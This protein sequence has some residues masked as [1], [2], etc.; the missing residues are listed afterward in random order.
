MYR[1]QDASKGFTANIMNAQSAVTVLNYRSAASSFNTMHS[2]Q[3]EEIQV[4]ASDQGFTGASGDGRIPAIGSLQYGRSLSETVKISINVVAMNTAPSILFDIPGASEGAVLR[5]GVE[6]DELT[7]IL[8]LSVA[9]EDMEE[10]VQSTLAKKLWMDDQQ[11][12]P[13]IKKM[14]AMVQVSRGV[15]FFPVLTNLVI[16]SDFEAFYITLTTRY[17]KHDLCRARN[18]VA[19]PVGE[20]GRVYYANQVGD[21]FIRGACAKNLAGEGCVSGDEPECTCR[22]T[23]NCDNGRILLHIRPIDREHGQLSLGYYRALLYAIATTD[24]RT[25]GGVPWYPS[26]HLFTTGHICSNDKACNVAEL[27]PCAATGS[28]RCCANLNITCTSH[29]E[30]S[31]KVEFGSLCGCMWGGISTRAN[32]VDAGNNGQCGPWLPDLSFTEAGE[33]QQRQTQHAKSREDWVLTCTQL[34]CRYGYQRRHFDGGNV[35]AQIQVCRDARRGR[36]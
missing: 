25:C 11:L 18:L 8:G 20:N 21:N 30:C 16:L 22:I 7:E 9:D 3:T 10:D 13:Y 19:E 5:Y 6:E 4:A 32:R 35:C 28:C 1:D 34:L 33:E 14:S 29:Q 2:G 15:L 17:P 36:V 12:A 26:P 24:D 23:D 27:Q 31:D